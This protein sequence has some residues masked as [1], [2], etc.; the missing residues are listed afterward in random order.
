[1]T[2][3]TTPQDQYKRDAHIYEYGS[4]ANPVMP[5]I[6]VLVHPPELH[7]TGPT[8]VLP[9]DLSSHMEIADGPATSPNLMASFVRVCE[10]ESIATQATATSQAFYIIRGNGTSTSQEHGTMEWST[11][12]M[13]VL[14]VT[15]GEV[16][17]T[18]STAE[19]YGGAALYW[20]HDQP[21]LDYLGVLPSG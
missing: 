2:T 14:P 6:P 17:H 21:L 10:G 9:F 12:D 16:T 18:C 11:G 19:K 13:L 8:R 3:M 1:M 4:A 20:I 5:P 15:P 7:A